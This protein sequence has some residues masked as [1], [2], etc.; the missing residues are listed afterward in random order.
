MP[1]K[2]RMSGFH[3]AEV[4]W[5][6]TT[7]SFEF[8]AVKGNDMSFPNQLNE[9]ASVTFQI[10]QP[11]GKYYKRYDIEEQLPFVG[12]PEELDDCECSY[13]DTFYLKTKRVQ[14]VHIPEGAVVFDPCPA[15]KDSEPWTEEQFAKEF[16]C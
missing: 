7:H 5:L 12:L 4:N 11:D 3:F 8:Y 16:N 15:P 1:Y 2:A 13:V 9:K 6:G 10:L 14:K